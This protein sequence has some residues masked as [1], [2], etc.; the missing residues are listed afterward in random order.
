[1]HRTQIYLQDEVFKRLR[2]RSR[3]QGLSI[4]ELIRRAVEKDLNAEPAADAE[5]FFDR[6]KPLE[7]FAEVLPETYV[8]ALRNKSRLLRRG[9]DD[10][11]SLSM[12]SCPAAYASVMKSPPMRHPLPGGRSTFIPSRSASRTVCR[13]R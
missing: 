10:D 12:E 9:A 7:S 8:R 1:M 2:I 6:L 5:A 4:S 11:T 3:A 13:T